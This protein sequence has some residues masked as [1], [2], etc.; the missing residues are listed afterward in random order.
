MK[1]VFLSLITIFIVLSLSIVLVKANPKT[2]VVLEEGVQIRTDGNNGLKWVANVSNHKDSNVYGFLFAQG[3]LAEVNINT[4]NVINQVVEG[5]TAEEPVMSATMTKFPKSAVAQ[6][7]SVVAYVKDGETYTYSNVV[8]RNLAEIALGAKNKNP[9]G[10]FITDVVNYV[11][12]NYMKKYNIGDTIFINNPVY[13]ANPV[14]I[15]KLFVAD[16]NEKFGTNWTEIDYSTFRAS[17]ADGSL[18]LTSTGDA[19]CSGT[20][21]YEFFNTDTVTSLKWKWLLEYMIGV[22]GGKVHPL[23]Q[24]NAL[25]GDGTNSDNY[26]SGMQNFMHLTASITNFFNGGSSRDANNDIVFNDSKYSKI[27]EYNKKIYSTN[28][29]LIKINETL[30][31]KSLISANGYS[32]EGYLEG[33]N[34]YVN[35]YTIASKSVILVPSYK[36]INYSIKYLYNSEELLLSPSQYT[37]KDNDIILPKYEKIGYVFKGWY[38]S[39]TFEEGTEIDKIPTG[40]FGDKVI[41]G[42]FEKTSNVSVNVTL[43]PNGGYWDATTTLDN[44]TILKQ[45]TLTRYLTRASSTG[46]D[47][48]LHTGTYIYWYHL[49]LKE[50]SIKGIYEIVS[51]GY[52]SS[53]VTDYNLSI[54]WH[55]S[56]TDAVSKTALNALYEDS[57]T[58]GKYVILENVPSESSSACSI[59]VNVINPSEVTKSITKTLIEQEELP[60]PIS[61]N[62]DY[63]FGGWKSSVDSSV[64]TIY[65]GYAS[66]PGDITYTAE[67]LSQLQTVTINFD[68]N[69]GAFVKYDTVDA[70]IADFLKDYNTARGKSYTP[71]QFYELGSMEEISGA[72]LFLYNA[73][74]KAKWKWLVNYIADVAG[75]SN[76]AA[77]TNFYNYSSQSELDAA[78]SNYI[79]SVAYELRGW[80]GQA[81]Y[82]KNSGFK[83]ADYSNESVK[84]AFNAA[85]TLPTSYV[86]TDPCAL[87]IPFRQNYTFKGWYTNEE[88]TG[89]AVTTYPGYYTNPGDVTYYAKWSSTIVIEY[90][91]DPFT[92]VGNSIQ[93]TAKILGELIGDFIWESKNTNIATVDQTGKITGVKEGTA[94]I[95][96]YDSGDPSVNLTIQISIVSEGLSE[97]FSIISNAH[98][99]SI[100]KK[101]DLRIGTSSS[102]YNADIYG[103]VSKILFNKPLY[104]DEKYLANGIATGNYYSNS[105]K[106]TGLEFITVH[107]TAG[108]PASSDTDNNASYFTTASAGVSIHYVTGNN[109]TYSDGTQSSSVYKCMSHDHGAWHAGDSNARYHSNSNKTNSSGQLIFSW[110]PTGVT[111]DGADLMDIEW[112]ASD[113]FYFEINGKKTSIKLPSTWNYKYNGTYRN[114]NHIY[115]SNGTISA[116]SGY[117]AWGTTFSNRTPESFFNDQ[118]FPVKVI[119]GEYYMG[120]TWWSYGQVYEGR[121]CGS[122]GNLNSIGIESCVNEGSDLWLTWQ[123]TAQLVAKLCYD[124]GL[125]FERIKG[126][127]F[128]DGK[129]CPQPLLANDMEIWDEF[130]ELVKYEYEL[131]TKFSNYTI[132]FVSN[133]TEFVSNTGRVIKIPAKDTTVSYTV[134]LTDKTTGNSN[135]VTYFTIIPG[136][137]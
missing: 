107:Y 44:A 136:M 60:T 12:D 88:F 38:L 30:S 52:G 137:E 14:E 110:M 98:N 70:A 48:S 22:A 120:P 85:N 114:T 106:D 43:N 89:D 104:I 73:T 41:Y 101:L 20:N 49:L 103:S 10:T 74:Y 15:E 42:K 80:V 111:Y 17:A 90:D 3:D 128:F 46:Y 135:S 5:V 39:S 19:N 105:V 115:N 25:L 124:N 13:E 127:H 2:S 1:K 72:S 100:F 108:F 78:N 93:L 51:K 56:L 26:G 54:I 36:T 112:S 125:G 34:L 81:Q 119:D 57:S 109:G 96:V 130:I 75:S 118:G 82:T 9:E 69:G 76:K 59:T 33:E 87:P 132:S 47:A 79:Y 16:W 134:T 129:D 29:T 64:V 86:Y 55:G 61:L 6:D 65:P 92:E 28:P 95:Y 123:T 31:L 77:Y 133:N 83:T 27:E 21:M 53:S 32:F 67:W 50:T 58:V 99:D 131:L 68:T 113:D 37:I 18:P 24:A 91:T 97:L 4:V 71:K 66:N 11:A 40:S 102:G 94:T 122:G 121:I 7:I 45:A 63:R 84:A 126:H 8:V 35:S 23:R 117:S 62:E 116:Q